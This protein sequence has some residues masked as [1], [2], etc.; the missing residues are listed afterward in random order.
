MGVEGLGL[1]WETKSILPRSCGRIGS[2]WLGT[3]LREGRLP[4]GGTRLSQERFLQSEPLGLVP[5]IGPCH[6]AENGF[7]RKRTAKPPRSSGRQCAFRG[8]RQLAQTA[9][10]RNLYR[11]EALSAL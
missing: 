2:F 3:G 1:A 5:R 4:E 6:E 10:G 11:F 8:C 7:P 9:L